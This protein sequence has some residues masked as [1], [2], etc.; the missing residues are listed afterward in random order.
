MIQSQTYLSSVKVKHCFPLKILDSLKHSSNTLTSINFDS[1]HYSNTTRFDALSY[2]TQLESLQ[3]KYCKGI[4]KFIQPLLSITPLKIKTFVFF[5]YA[6]TNLIETLTQIQLLIQ[7][8][9]YYIENLG[10]SI[11]DEELRRKIFDVIIDSCEKIKFLHLNYI[12]LK[13]IS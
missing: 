1:C 8:I 9:G 13:N 10:L 6:N 3:F 12:D 7:K 5:D 4:N 2:L 11:Y